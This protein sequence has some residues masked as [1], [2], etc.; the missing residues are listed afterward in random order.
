MRRLALIFFL[1]L[2]ACADDI[3]AGDCYLAGNADCAE[4]WDYWPYYDEAWCTDAY[5]EGWETAGCEL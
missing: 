5:A 1:A 3:T 4:G 2:T